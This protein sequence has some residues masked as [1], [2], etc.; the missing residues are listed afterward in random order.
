MKV[1]HLKVVFFLVRYTLKV[2]E[3]K[4]CSPLA[5]KNTAQGFA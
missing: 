2:E 5:V 4:K 1:K 3:P